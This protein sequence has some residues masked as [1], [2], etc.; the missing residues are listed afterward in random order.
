M[1]YLEQYGMSV[2]QGL[3]WGTGLVIITTVFHK[4]L[5][6]TIIIGG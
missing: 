3:G 6:W 2:M 5:G 1:R 4:V